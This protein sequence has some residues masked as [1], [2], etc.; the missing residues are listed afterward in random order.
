MQKLF[1]SVALLLSIALSVQSCKKDSLFSNIDKTTA[2]DVLAHNDL[3]EQMD[4]DADEA[5]DGFVSGESSDRGDCPSV[6]FAQPKGT[7]PNT[8]TLDYSDAGCTKGGHTYQGKIIINQTNAMNVDGAVRT[9]SFDQFFIEGVQI[10][11]SKTITNAGVNTS[12]LPSF[13]VNVDET[14]TFPDGTTATHQAV[15]NRVMTEGSGTQA[16]FDDVWTITGNAS[17]VNRKGDSYTVTIT[18]PLVKKNPCAWIGAGVIEF[19]VN[20]L[21]RSLDFGDGACDR[22]A[23]LTL[24]N[25]TE[26]N[27]KSATTGG[28]N[29]GITLFFG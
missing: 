11:G 5:L 23:T 2:E 17:G 29:R 3:S 15:R 12:G 25:G 26:K 4:I 16:R 7:W 10:E 19:T 21:T 1:F 6:T 24:A 18:T 14:L 8:I 28:N 9:L 22:D 13:N 27:V 20:N